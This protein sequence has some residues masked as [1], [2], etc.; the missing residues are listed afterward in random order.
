MYMQLYKN[1][2]HYRD[3]NAQ[4]R[5]ICYQTVPYN[6]VAACTIVCRHYAMG[7]TL[8]ISTLLADNI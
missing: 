3:Q 6:S 5:S 7:F 2:R 8:V 1:W 4:L